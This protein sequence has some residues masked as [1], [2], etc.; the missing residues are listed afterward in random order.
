MN[1]DDFKELFQTYY[2]PAATKD[3]QRANHEIAQIIIQLAEWRN[4]Q[5]RSAAAPVELAEGHVAVKGGIDKEFSRLSKQADTY[6]GIAE[7]PR[8]SQEQRDKA[9]DKLE[10]I[11][12]VLEELSK[13][14]RELS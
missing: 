10:Q 8:A 14:R 9:K 7:H 12:P 3:E 13:A 1:K 11:I 5:I 4:N 2:R 6:L